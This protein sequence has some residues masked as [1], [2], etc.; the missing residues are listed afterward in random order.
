MNFTLKYKG[1]AAGKLDPQ[2]AAFL[3]SQPAGGDLQNITPAQLRSA[4]SALLKYAPQPA[5]VT[6]DEFAV[7]A[8]DGYQVRVRVYRKE[9]GACAAPVMFFHGGCW[10]FCNIDVYDTIC[11][12]LCNDTGLTLFS[13]D[14][15]LAPEC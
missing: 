1:G 2:I 12:K 9:E 8:R 13:V 6:V 7:E 15:R 4:P 11:R 5:L 14:Y 10:V 3:K